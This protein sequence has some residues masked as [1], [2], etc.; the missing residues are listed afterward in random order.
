MGGKLLPRQV[1]FLYTTMVAVSLL[2]FLAGVLVGKT[3]FQESQPQMAAETG[4]SVPPEEAGLGEETLNQ[5]VEG[6][7]TASR[8]EEGSDD[9]AA[10]T[11]DESSDSTAGG[12]PPAQDSQ[13]PP[14]AET[15]AAPAASDAD[16]GSSASAGEAIDRG[17][18]VQLAAS[19]SREDAEGLMKRLRDKGLNDGFIVEP[20][21]SG[22]QFFRVWYG[23]FAQQ[24]QAQQAAERLGSAGFKTFVTRKSFPAR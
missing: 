22:D 17:W 1:F 4:Q 10:S 6:A 20:E 24:E 21:F 13:E 11:P 19:N 3:Y 12:Q 23:R 14:A 16:S 5:L 15:P 18:T 7:R 2:F 8:R 9:P